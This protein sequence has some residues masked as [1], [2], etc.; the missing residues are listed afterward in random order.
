[1]A[2]LGRRADLLLTPFPFRFFVT[3]ASDMVE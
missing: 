3:E 2:Y 1:M